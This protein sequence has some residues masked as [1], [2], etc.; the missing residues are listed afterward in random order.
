MKNYLKQKLL[1][2]CLMALS[3]I[4]HQSYG[5]VA[6][7]GTATSANG[8]TTLTS[9]SA[10]AGTNRLL[11]VTFSDAASIT[12]ASATFGGTP[13]TKISEVNDGATAS[14]AIFVLALGTSGSAT[15]GNVVAN[16]A[17][18]GNTT[19]IVSASVYQNVNQTTPTSGLQTAF[20]NST[21][22]TL[23]VPSQASD[24][25]FDFY[26]SFHSV[27]TPIPTAGGGQT[28]TT[29]TAFA[30]PS[31]F[32]FYSISTKAG[33]AS[34]A[35]SR[36]ATGHCCYIHIAFSLQEASSPSTFWTDL[37]EDRDS[38]SIGTRTPT[39]GF[40]CGGPHQLRLIFVGQPMLT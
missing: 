38:P 34:V 25:V 39:G 12:P 23:N 40:T 21:T 37:F 4:V 36:T 19:K 17:N 2:L 9:F 6:A 3:F 20:A 32:G 27:N 13:M 10:P 16:N 14:D 29:F 7:L 30:V 18:G 5:Q 15:V 33:A 35:M 22:S 31:G 11:V 26:D 24:L 1:L 28:L 8:T